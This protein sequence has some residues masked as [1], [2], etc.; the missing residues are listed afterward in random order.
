MTENDPDFRP[1]HARSLDGLDAFLGELGPQLEPFGFVIKRG[2]DERNGRPWIVL[3]NS[4]AGDVA[5]QATDLSTLEIS[6]FQA[7][8]KA[9][10]ESSPGFS[11]GSLAATN[12]VS[13]LQ[14]KITRTEAEG[15]L[16]ALVSRKWLDRSK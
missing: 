14:G 10:V 2:Q 3:C 16:D 12:L 13:G 15:L 9:I 7:I 4:E 6:Y 11:I 8:I 5:K 1:K